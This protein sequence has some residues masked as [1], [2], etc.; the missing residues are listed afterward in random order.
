MTDLEA[1]IERL[2]NGADQYATAPQRR[3]LLREAAAYLRSMPGN[4]EAERSRAG[5]SV[6]A[7]DAE[8]GP[9]MNQENPTITQAEGI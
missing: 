4:A 9:G 5:T 1:L 6:G 3:R 2:Q 7:P 8:L